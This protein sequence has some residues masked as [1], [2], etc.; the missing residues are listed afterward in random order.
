MSRRT[1][2]RLLSSRFKRSG[3]GLGEVIPAA[4]ILFAIF[5]RFA[6]LAALH[7]VEDDLADIIRTLEPP[8]GEYGQGHGSILL[9]GIH[10]DALEQLGRRHMAHLAPCRLLVHTHGK[11]KRLTDEVVGVGLI[12][13]VL[14]TNGV[15]DLG[16]L[17]L[18]HNI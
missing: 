11:I 17:F 9:K 14:A 1:G 13:G 12:S 10:P 4:E 18:V 3:K 16:E 2:S 6:K 7:Q 8:G 15:N 5:V